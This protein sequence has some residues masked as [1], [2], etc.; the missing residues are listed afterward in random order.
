MTDINLSGC[1]PNKKIGDFIIIDQGGASPNK[2]NNIIIK[3]LK[4][5]NES[6]IF[7]EVGVFG[8]G[9]LLEFHKII[10]N[11]KCKMYGVDKWDNQKMM[12][13]IEEHLWNKNHWQEYINIQRSCYETLCKIIE[14]Y[15]YN[16]KLI[17]L[18][19]KG[20]ET[21][22]DNFEENSID[23]IHIDGDHSYKSVTADC[24]TY[25]KKM[26]KGGV[27]LFDDWNWSETKKAI[28]DFSKSNNLNVNV[29]NNNKCY[30]IC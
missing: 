9:S 3:K 16:I 13:G 30:I 21:V 25:L 10:N 18:E 4:S 1:N 14:T 24:K 29:I 7:I 19:E 27:M 22:Y 8:G 20:I 6:S 15:N 5:L 23:F 28:T 12:N 2:L 17:K 11:N 26:K